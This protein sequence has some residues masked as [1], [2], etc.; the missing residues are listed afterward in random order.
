MSQET[1]SH[2]FISVVLSCYNASR[3]LSET[4][5]CV[6]NQS[7]TEF[8][9]VI[10]DDGSKD[11][12]PDIINHYAAK[13]DRVVPIFK[14]N[15]GLPDS[16]NIG[17][18][19]ARGGWIARIDADDL[20]ELS[21]LKEHVE[22]TKC[23][24]EV[25]LIG[26]NC[27]EIDE[28]GGVL[29]ECQYPE[30]HDFLIRNLERLM[31]FFPHSSAFYRADLARLVGG[32]NPRIRKAEDWRLWLALAAKGGV[33]C[34]QKPLVKIRIHDN[35]ISFSDGG[36]RQQID[37]VAATVCHFLERANLK[38]PSSSENFDDWH[39]FLNWIEHEPRLA[40]YLI[41]RDAWS[42]ARDGYFSTD[43][44]I[45]GL[46]RF[47]KRLLYSGQLLQLI[48]EKYFGSSLPEQLADAWRKG[49]YW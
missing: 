8:E 28:N 10:I 14:A 25:V 3:W 19:K 37:A 40:Q 16:L 4:I 46:V 24:P 42:H 18:R 43:L 1:C 27:H 33:Y 47:T 12:T 49:K 23:M 41:R 32:Y 35:Q 6:L 26:S 44:R 7:F 39:L 11:D 34:I 30:S 22:V 45:L 29:R 48:L 36:R 5:E 20:W 17:L 13:D 9:L 15:S 38:D 2:P 21:H 31:R